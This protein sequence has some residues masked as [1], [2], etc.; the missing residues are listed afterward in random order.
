MKIKLGSAL[1]VAGMFLA[2]CGGG[3]GAKARADQQA[4]ETVQEGSAAGVTSTIAGPGETLPPITGTN[5]D[6]TSAFALNPN[7]VPTPQQQAGMTAPPQPT[8]GGTPAYP[9]NAPMMSSSPSPSPAPVSRASSYTPRPSQTQPTQQQTQ[10]AEPQQSEPAETQ[11][12]EPVAK[13]ADTSTANNDTAPPAENKPAPAQPPAEE[14]P[15]AEDTS[16]QQAE[17]PPPPP[18]PA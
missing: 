14:K 2:A 8:Y 10:Q 15:P 13:P 4:Y 3:G 1:M 9:S 11:P 6:T 5:A 16:G 18:P 17:E 12:A 7:A